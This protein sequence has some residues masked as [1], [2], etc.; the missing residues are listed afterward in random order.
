MRS[1]EKLWVRPRES[2][3]AV[4]RLRFFTSSSSNSILTSNYYTYTIDIE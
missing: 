4:K 3:K 1:A 2:T